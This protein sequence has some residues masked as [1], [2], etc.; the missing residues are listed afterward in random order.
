MQELF[1]AGWQICKNTQDVPLARNRIKRRRINLV[2]DYSSE[3]KHEPGRESDFQPA[4]QTDPD[5]QI[6]FLEQRGGIRGGPAGAPAAKS[7][8]CGSRTAEDR[9]PCRRMSPG[10]NRGKRR[11]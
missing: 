5:R 4:G 9:P 3:L 1:P 6:T 2:R 7:L 8:A 10:R 11:Q